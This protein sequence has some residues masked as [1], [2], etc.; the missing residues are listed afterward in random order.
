MLDSELRNKNL[1][2]IKTNK[3]GPT[4]THVIYAD[5]IVLFPKASRED[6][7][8]I[9]R[10]LEKY[11]LGSGQLVNRNKSGIYF[12]KHTQSPTWRTIKSILQVKALK[13]DVVYLGAPFLLS[14][15]PSKDFIYLQHKLEARLTG[16]RSKCLSW[17]RI[18]TLFSTVAKTI[19][20]YTMST[21][22]I[23]NK[24]CDK[25]DSL[26]RRFWWK[27]KNQDGNFL[28]MKVWD[29][30]YHLRN[31]GGL[32]FKKAKDINTALLAKLA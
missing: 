16:W 22:N 24:V 27:P 14:R 28:A 5:D 30:L 10:I 17:A 20:T 32:G 8:T 1:Y 26:T 25:L 12:S 29:K 11:S 21:F 2:G 23:P 6:V 3:S 4:I 13:K 19:P 31:K 7:G 9:S 18:R 15:A